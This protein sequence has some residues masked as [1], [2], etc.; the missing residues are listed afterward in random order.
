MTSPTDERPM[1]RT[2]MLVILIQLVVVTALWWAGQF[3]SR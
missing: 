1:G 3:F 2:Y